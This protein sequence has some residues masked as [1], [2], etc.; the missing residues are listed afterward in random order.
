MT[1]AITLQR[2]EPD[3]TPET[4]QERIRE[5]GLQN[6][7]LLGWSHVHGY[8]QLLLEGQFSGFAAEE[9]ENAFIERTLSDTCSRIAALLRE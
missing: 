1:N 9:G 3:V 8:A 4:L 7:V 2:G 5:K 6:D